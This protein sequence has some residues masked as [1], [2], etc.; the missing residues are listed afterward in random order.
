MFEALINAVRTP[1]I[2]RRILFVLGML[3]VY[4]ALAV[5]PVPDVNQAELTNLIERLPFLQLL[6][7]FSGGGLATFSIVAMG[8]NPYINA[9][10][11][12]QLMTGVVPRLQAL[13]REGDYGRQKINQYTRYLCVPLALLQAYGYLA[14]LSTENIVAPANILS[15]ETLSQMIT[16]AAGTILAMWIGELITERG[17]G[18]GISF[19]IFAGI[20]AQAPQGVVSFLQNPDLAEGVLWVLLALVIVAVIVYI[21]E[22]QRRI[23]IQYASRVR[24]RR[25]YQGGATF[26]PLRVNQAGVIPIIFAVSILIFPTQIASYFMAPIDTP[27]GGGTLVNQVAAGI[28]GFLDPN[29]IPYVVGYFLLT[30]GFTYFYTAFTFKPDETADQLRKNGGF[31]PGIRPGAPTR[32]YLARVVFRLSLAGALF[33]ATIAVAPIIMG[34]ALTGAA[35]GFA[36]GGTAL[37]IVVSVVVETMKQIEAQLMM[38]NYEGF[39]R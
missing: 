8:V 27:P 25:M 9:S 31:I 28:V 2:R 26:L 5:V 35:G 6:D 7:L 11:I 14:L 21:Q 3:V 24:G 12:M 20:V 10:I 23:P 17:I 4:R 38:R 15:L 39:I 29:G 18:N 34:T 13:S 22:G 16:L 36:L 37:L 1:D 19:I 33:L 30:M 32:D